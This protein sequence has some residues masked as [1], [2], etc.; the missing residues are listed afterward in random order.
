MDPKEIILAHDKLGEGGM[1]RNFPPTQQ[2]IK[3][4]SVTCHL[5]HEIL[6]I[7]SSRTTA[8]ISSG[9]KHLEGMS[10]DNMIDL[11]EDFGRKTSVF[12]EDVCCMV[13]T[14]TTRCGEG[15]VGAY[16]EGVK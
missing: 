7:M 8:Q 1:L 14:L 5:P 10:R 11:W 4:R 15:A 9:P 6:R 2:V 13:C 12:K 3:Q 16:V